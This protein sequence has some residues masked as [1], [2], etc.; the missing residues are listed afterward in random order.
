MS[1]PVAN[2][3]LLLAAAIWGGGFVAQ[4]HAMLYVGVGWFTCLRFVLA[5]AVVA[6]LGLMEA[7]RTRNTRSSLAGIIPLGLTFAV[8]SL[9]QQFA[10]ETTSVTHIGFLTGLYAIFVPCLEAIV[11]KR[12]PHPLIWLAALLAFSG[13]WF[14]GGSFDG[15]GRGDL[16]AVAAALG[17]AVQIILLQRFVQRTGRPVA[18]AM[19]QSFCCIVVGGILSLVS[20]PITWGSIVNAMPELLYAGIF[21]GGIAFLLQAVCQRFTSAT[22]AAVMLMAESLFAALFAVLLLS[23]RLTS[24]GWAGC[25]LLFLSLV[26]AQVGP[27]LIGRPTVE[28]EE[29]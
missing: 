29:V 17:F 25:A 6:P 24:S 14:L 19:F 13:T 22:E 21:S 27:I 10:F 3:G 16:L 20:E 9:L 2:L 23:E 5:F 8:A 28:A 18:A 4:S 7:K 11:F 15:L 1:R 12:N 26:V